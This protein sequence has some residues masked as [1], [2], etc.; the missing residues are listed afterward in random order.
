MS[1]IEMEPMNSTV[2][3]ETLRLVALFCGRETSDKLLYEGDEQCTITS[4]AQPKHFY[5]T[6]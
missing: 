2:S 4:L 1:D 6:A 3:D 5:D